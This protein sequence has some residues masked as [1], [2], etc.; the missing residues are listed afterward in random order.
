MLLHRPHLC[1]PLGI[2]NTLPATAQSIIPP[3]GY[4]NPGQFTFNLRLSKTISFGRETQRQTSTGG[5]S[6][7]GHIFKMLHVAL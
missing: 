7:A 3:Y 4:D 1:Y 5:C 2:F 6:S